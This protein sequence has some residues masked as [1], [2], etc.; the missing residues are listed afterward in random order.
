MSRQ[1]FYKLKK[2][3]EEKKN[4]EAFILAHVKNIRKKHSRMGT[5]KLR[6]E[7]MEEIKQCGRGFGKNKLF[8]LLREND[9]LL[10]RRRRYSVTTNSNHPFNKHTN[11][12]DKQTITAPDQAWVSDITYLRT[13]NKFV[14]LSLVTDVYSR[15]IVGFNVDVSLAVE[16]AIGAVKMA[17]GKGGGAKGVIHHSDRGSQYCCHAYNELAK[18]NGIK[19]SM[20]EAGNCYDNAIAERVNGILKDEYLLDSEFKDKKQVERAVKEAIYLYNYER[21]H[22]SLNLKKPA[23]V[24]FNGKK[25]LEKEERCSLKDA[26]TAPYREQETASFRREKLKPNNEN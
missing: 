6:N 18:K 16:G 23:D 26:G 17:I 11:L 1:A 22:W 3:T 8:D 10:K 14:Y 7:L 4:E 21:P 2:S 15:K 9:L 24:Y 13:R 19:M 12:L 25:K 5:L 20:G